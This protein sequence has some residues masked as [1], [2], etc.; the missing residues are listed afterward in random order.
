MQSIDTDLPVVPPGAKPGDRFPPDDKV[1]NQLGFQGMRR[2]EINVFAR[3]F[4]KKGA[5]DRYPEDMAMVPLVTLMES[6]MMQG[7]FGE[8]PF[9]LRGPADEIADLK[10]RLA[11]M[12]KLIA[13]N[14]PQN[15]VGDEVA[16]AVTKSVALV[17]EDEPGGEDGPEAPT[18]GEVDRSCPEKPGTKALVEYHALKAKARALGIPTWRKKKAVLV[19]EIEEAEARGA[20]PTDGD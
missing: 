9:G 5:I 17:T 4:V 20:K 3:P 15:S 14:I 13:G 18:P 1:L 6:Y 19:A 2:T 12:E 7:K 16:S 11:K 10:T 8:D